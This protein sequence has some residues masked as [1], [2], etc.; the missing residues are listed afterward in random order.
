M[1]GT[2]SHIPKQRAEDLFSNI[3]HSLPP[4]VAQANPRTTTPYNVRYENWYRTIPYALRIVSFAQGTGN[5]LI[6]GGSSSP[7]ENDTPM[8][9]FFPVNPE[10][11]S[12]NTPFATVVTPTIGGIVQEHSGAVFYN[13]TISGT[14]GVIPE[15]DHSTG[16][17]RAADKELRPLAANDGLVNPNVIGGFGQNAI[18]AINSAVSAITGTS[19]K[20]VDH[21]KNRKSGYTA[22]HVLYKFIWLY[23]FAK[24]NGAPVQLRFM[25]YKDNNM[26]D[27]VV[28]NF[29]LNRDKG[30]PHLYQY[31][32]QLKAWKLTN[33][34]QAPLFSLK[35]R[36]KSLGLDEGPSVKALA[37]RVINDTKTVL[38]NAAGL[39]NA[40]AQDLV[41]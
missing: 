24:S 11:I 35:D 7:S 27:C 20:M 41:F 10:S 17:P 32:I 23:H 4:D 37:F 2:G 26:Y 12:I 13:I 36:L 22:F 16:I 6:L 21:S 14:T 25:N 28:T 15:I 31:T 34:H 19:S 9:F 30:R 3:Y 38:N 18:N 29:N 8:H 40:A 1:A 33:V 39:L 5:P